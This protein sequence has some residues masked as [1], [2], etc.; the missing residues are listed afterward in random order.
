VDSPLP[1]RRATTIR[2]RPWGKRGTRATE[3]R[4]VRLDAKAPLTE[5][6]IEIS[7]IEINEI[8]AAAYKYYE[9]HP[10]G[11]VVITNNTDQTHTKVKLGF[12]IKGFIDFPAEI[13][14]A[15]ITPKQRVELQ[16]KPVFSN[17]ILDVTE[18]SPLQS[19]ISLTYDVAGVATAVTRSFPVTLY[20]RHAI[21]W[22]Q[23]AK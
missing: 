17:K 18:N 2:S 20:E 4:G 22:D 1:T 23:K 5:P 19:E 21:Q 10:L 15:E 9:T 16:L 3:R 6:P 7:R 14:I 13:E 12:A 8:F 11:K